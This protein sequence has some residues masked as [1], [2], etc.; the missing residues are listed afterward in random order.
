LAA[1]SAVKIAIEKQGW[2]RVYQDELVAAG[3]D[4]AVDP[5]GLRLYL[6]GHEQ[7]IQVHNA[8]PGRFDV[9]D[10]VEFHGVGQDTLYTDQHVYWL[11]AAGDGGMRVPVLNRP[12][13]PPLL[14][15][16]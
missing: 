8:T 13:V 16:A 14:G 9:G 6:H 2:Y 10:F 15:M 3:L 12:A 11:V 4:P 1:Q 5:R 7:P